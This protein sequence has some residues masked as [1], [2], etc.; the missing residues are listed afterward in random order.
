MYSFIGA[1]ALTAKPSS[2]I[3]S[4]YNSFSS[5]CREMDEPILITRNGESDLVVMNHE[6]YNN[7][8]D[9]MSLTIELLE[10]DRDLKAAPSI[11][12]ADVFTGLREMIHEQIQS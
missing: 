9:R 5:M 3:R 7:M 10:A 4:D 8:I 2:I 6:V 11:P 1:K 12:A